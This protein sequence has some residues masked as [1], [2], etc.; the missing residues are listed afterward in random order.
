MTRQKKPKQK[1]PT[2]N[3]SKEKTLTIRIDPETLTIM[4][5]FKE[6]TGMTKSELVRR[7]IHVYLLMNWMNEKHPHPKLIF[8]WNMFRP[9]LDLADESTIETIAKISFQNGTANQEVYKQ[10]YD[11]FYPELTDQKTPEF[12]LN[13][14]TN[15]VFADQAQNWLI[16]SNWFREENRYVF[17]AK[18]KLG[19]NFSLFLSKLFDLYLQ[20]IAY[21]VKNLETKVVD[22]K[23][24]EEKEVL[25]HEQVD[26]MVLYIAQRN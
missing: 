8:A 20:S 3:S 24:L 21:C 1:Q 15:W 9:L 14:L 2:L 18:H 4:D 12:Y 10:Y 26:I 17:T 7:S 13:L 19:P 16:D 11:L 22:T 23:I 5:L 6:K 25:N